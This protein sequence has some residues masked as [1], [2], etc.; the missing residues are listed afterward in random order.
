M[1]L[2]I[3]V[4]R[5]FLSA[6]LTAHLSCIKLLRGKQLMHETIKT[7]SRAQ[8]ST[9]VDS[10]AQIFGLTRHIMYDADLG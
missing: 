3:K 4:L 9:N 6:S 1:R 5:E 2:D 10:D 7:Q 8:N